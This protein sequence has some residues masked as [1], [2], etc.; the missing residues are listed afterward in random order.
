MDEPTNI[1]PAPREQGASPGPVAS[2][3]A[4]RLATIIDAVERAAAGVIDDAESQARDY[5]ARSRRRAD[6]LGAERLRSI[7]EITSRLVEQGEEI[8]RRADALIAAFDEVTRE[9]E[10]LG[11][12]P[13][14]PSESA[15]VPPFA[16]AAEPAPE[17]GSPS[18]AAPP[19]PTGAEPRRT[20]T[21]PEGAGPLRPAPSR[22]RPR[23]GRA[24]PSAARALPASRSA[25][26][27]LLVT[28]MAM[29]GASR[30]EIEKRLREELGVRDGAQIIDSILGPEE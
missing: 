1:S 20:A 10:E 18:A 19:P 28:Q 8:R 9:V 3:A 26:T 5:L 24:D 7:D 21:A 29:A 17:R 6:R 25:G 13:G 15:A 16:T 14:E 11:R 30:E 4:E 2:T 27:R 22:P 23:G 12:R